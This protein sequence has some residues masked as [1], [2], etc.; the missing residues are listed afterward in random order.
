[1]TAQIAQYSG[2]EQQVKTNA[3]LEKLLAGNKQSE[4]STAVGYIGK[5]IETVGSTGQVVGGQ[6]AFT[7]ILPQVA[8]NTQITIKN[9]AGST[10]FQGEGTNNSGRN[11]IVWDGKSSVDGKQQPDGTYTISVNAVD[12]SGKT[13]IPELRAVG[14][15]SGVEND[16]A[17]NVTLSVVQ[18]K[19][20]FDRILAVREP[21]RAQLGS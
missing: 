7:Y 8:Q 1:M 20:S 10:V 16:V 5:E 9:A 13:M 19:T 3:N 17:G 18:S 12:A 15:V 11:L 2:V 4:L 14:I 6:G 21:T